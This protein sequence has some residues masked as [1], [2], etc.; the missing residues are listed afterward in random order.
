MMSCDVR[1]RTETIKFRF[2]LN[3]GWSNGSGMR[4]S[5]MGLTVNI[6]RIP[7]PDE[8]PLIPVP[9]SMTRCLVRSGHRLQ[10]GQEEKE[11]NQ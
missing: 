10:A 6:Y 7:A 5:R 1:A 8:S 9:E 4:S 11:R 3:S 2:E